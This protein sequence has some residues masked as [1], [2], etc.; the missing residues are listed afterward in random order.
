MADRAHAHDAVPAFEVLL[1]IPCERRDD[2]ALACAALRQRRRNALRLCPQRKVV[3][4]GRVTGSRG[5]NHLRTGMPFR[6]VIEK[7]VNR[8][9]IRL[10]RTRY[11]W[12]PSTFGGTGGLATPVF[13]CHG[14]SPAARLRHTTASFSA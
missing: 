11:H 13:Q 10:H 5:S 3:G 12:H 7:L 2:I 1:R 14:W 4:P 9:R 6:R 8:Q